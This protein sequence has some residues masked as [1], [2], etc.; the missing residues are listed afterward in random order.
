[1]LNHSK[2][3]FT[4]ATSSL[5]AAS[6]CIKDSESVNSSI[7]NLVVANSEFSTLEDAAIQCNLVYVLSNPNPNHP[8][9][10]FTVFAPNDKAFGRLGLLDSDD[11]TVLQTDFLTNTV[12]YHVSDG[13]LSGSNIEKGGVSA[14]AI[15]LN[16]RFVMAGQDRFINGSKILATD[17]TAENGTVHVIDKVLLATGVDIVQSAL[18]LRDT[19]VFKTPELTFLVEAV[20]YAELAN[21]LTASPGSP[22][23]TVFAP[24]DAAFRQ[25]GEDLGVPMNTPASIRQLPKDVVTAVLLN[26]VVADG[27]KFTSELNE[28]SVT[29]LSGAEVSVAKF[30]N[31]DL[32]LRGKGNDVSAK[33]VIPDIQVTNGVVHLID[34]VLLP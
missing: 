7:A 17:L 32:V 26:H 22:S 11:L 28:T 6:A 30:S 13:N 12:L 2:L 16:R 3:L 25:L 1:M 9:G 34:R 29:P 31:G 15:G 14:S 8:F 21:A 10:D 23:F 20:L 24:T 33:T 4:F 18:A 5:L 27:G 19:Q